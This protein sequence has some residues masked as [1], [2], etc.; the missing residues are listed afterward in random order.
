MVLRRTQA[1]V[2]THHAY[3]CV[4]QGTKGD[5][6]VAFPPFRPESFSV[7]RRN[8]DALKTLGAR[9]TY[10]FPIPG[11]GMFWE[12]DAAARCLRDGKLQPELHPNANAQLTMEIMDEA[13]KQGGF[14]YPDKLEWVREDAPQQ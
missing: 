12:A 14:A 3:S 8:D 11:H 6:A 5:I 1:V 9:T 7:A 4:I 10:E 2:R 13:R